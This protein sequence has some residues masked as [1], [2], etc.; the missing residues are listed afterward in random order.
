MTSHYCDIQNSDVIMA[1]GSNNA[2][3]HP[4]TMR[5]VQD[6][7]DKQD[8]TYIVVDPRFTRSASLADI[9][10]PL[11]SGTDIAFYGGM[12]KYII[13]NELWHKDFVLNYTNASYLV[14]P[15]F[16]FDDATGLFTG[17]DEE[18]KAYDAK[19]GGWAY[20]I[21]EEKPWDVEGPMSWTQAPGVPK[22]TPLVERIAKKDPTLQDPNCVFQLLKKQY[23]RY[24]MDMVSRIT[25]MPK[26]KLEAVYKAFSATG[27][28]DKTGS[29]FY[30]LG[31]TQ[32]HYGTQNIRAMAILQMLLGN[33]GV[34]GGGINALRGEANVQGST[35]Q[36]VLWGNL[37]GYLN[38]PVAAKHPTIAK[39]IETETAA[40]G[41]YTNKPK[42]FVSWLKEVYG[43]HA[44][45]ENDYAYDLFPKL[46]AKNYSTT[47]TFEKM[48]EG[49]IKGY[50]LF[51][52]NPCNSAANTKFVRNAMAKLDWLVSVDMYEHE[53]AA[54]FKAPDMDPA[55]IDTEVYQLPAACHY[56]KPGG[57]SN[58][59]RWVQWRYEA[60]KPQ[61]ESLA[62]MKILTK[63]ALKL[64]EL[65]EA[66][67]GPAKEQITKLYWPYVDE[68]GEGDIIRAAWAMNGYDVA[69]T[70]FKVGKTKLLKNFTQ[71]KADGTTAC[72]NWVYSGY[73]NNNDAPFDV[74]QQPTASRVKDDPSGLAL[75][76]KWSFAWPVNRRVLYNRASADI[77][78]KPY[79]PKRTL[80][81]WNGEKWVT[82]DV[83]DFAFQVV[84][85]D[86]TATPIPPNNK[87]FMMNSE[88]CARLW[89]P[90]L[91]DG[92]FPEH[93]EPF[94]SPTTNL[95]NGSQNSPAIMGA[96]LESVKRGDPKDY[97][98]VATSYSF[99]E[100]WQSGNQT[101]NLPWLAEVRPWMFVE[102]S[103]ELADEKGIANGDTV[104]VWNNRGEIKCPAMVTIRLKPFDIDG[105][106]TH[107][108][109]V[110]R[111]WGWASGHTRG[112]VANDLTV[113]VFDPNSNIPESKAFLV[114]V[115]KA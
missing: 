88:Q 66:E 67:G 79:D 90:S 7:K 95:L 10:A 9:Y 86:G 76:P 49:E 39:W 110:P 100:Q 75:F 37:P 65:Y 38:A 21:A 69:A 107:L 51:G 105:K 112:P 58:S 36:G 84:A 70:D 60:V 71:L 101:R 55:S 87:A 45:V 43:P 114:N 44:T 24:D 27:A 74:S 47:M 18:K 22:F 42:F 50:F 89:A 57:I 64:Q 12:F 52:Q 99:T 1:C 20:Q 80:V 96:N 73:F 25:G 94:E 83:P 113:N 98:I 15:G 81:E 23:E 34:A 115:E 28:P 13:D 111:H 108:I 29:I 14:D 72:A 93:Y 56:E 30:A 11:R 54:F 4:V 32:H 31:Q 103:Q 33:L 92:P 19:K 2:E 5:W 48:N 106:Q 63:M 78:G 102:I 59:G 8:C 35:D 53:S 85:P 46:G 3:N 17:W 77:N 41:Y 40:G 82:N 91:K 6:S 61:G 62:D 109:G 104:R 26:D 16:G 97:P 68:N